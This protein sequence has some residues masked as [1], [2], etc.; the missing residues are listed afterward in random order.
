MDFNNKKTFTWPVRTI[1]ILI[2]LILFK[3]LEFSILQRTIHWFWKIPFDKTG[4][5]ISIISIILILTP[6]IFFVWKQRRTLEE[7]EEKYKELAENLSVG[8]F[9]YSDGKITYVN[10]KILEKTGYH[11]DEILGYDF[12]NLIVAEDRPIILEFIEKRL[13]GKEKST[14]SQLRVMK[15]DHSVLDV[16]IYST[17]IKKNDKPVL[18][19]TIVDISERKR[20]EQLL[21]ELA[22]LDPLTGLANRRYFES[23]FQ[24]NWAA[25]DQKNIS[26]VLFI[27]IDEFKQ[28]NDSYGH[29]A[30]DLLLTELANR[31]MLSVRKEDTAIRFAGDEF[32]IFISNRDH[33][34]IIQTAE[35][36]IQEVNKPFSVHHNQISTS[37]SIGIAFF[38]EHGSDLKTLIRNADKAMYEAKKQGK[39]IYRIFSFEENS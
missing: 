27:D 15:K 11:K 2:G 8:I 23:N 1:F 6:F 18:I 10:Q 24:N 31:L 37:T 26:A 39:N 21:Q 25:I 4:E 20:N 33:H 9:M 13:S 12:Q 16:E 30:G 29:E 32:M 14:V 7:A 36:I 17:I 3:A 22:Y 34:S 38:P 35:R 5:L 28:I 19:G